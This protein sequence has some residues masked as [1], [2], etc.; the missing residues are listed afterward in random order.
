M[1]ILGNNMKCCNSNEQKKESI[2]EFNCP[3][4]NQKGI[5]VSL[6]TLK[7]LLIDDFKNKIKIEANY[8]YCKTSHCEVAYFSNITNHNFLIQNLKVKATAKDQGLDVNVCYCFGHTRE[9]IINEIKETGD[10]KVLENIK[11]LMKDPG[12]FCEKSNPEGTCCL[13]SVSSYIKEV[14]K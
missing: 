8:K 5:P 6:E 13:G 4:C 9:S 12:C 1:K 11:A 2:A 14:I 3:T 7:S 10:T